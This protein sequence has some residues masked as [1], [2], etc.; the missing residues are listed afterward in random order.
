M[1]LW[2]FGRLL[3]FFSSYHVTQ[4]LVKWYL[5]IRI[6]QLQSTG[7]IKVAFIWVDGVHWRLVIPI[8]FFTVLG[9]CW[10]S[11]VDLSLCSRDI[12]SST[13]NVIW[14]F[15]EKLPS[16]WLWSSE[17]VS[18]WSA[19]KEFESSEGGPGSSLGHNLARLG[20]MSNVLF[21]P[22]YFDCPICYQSSVSDL[23]GRNYRLV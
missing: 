6:D 4:D 2:N 13:L 12:W 18:L 1:F 14:P 7:H 16:P 9:C 5:S 22:E 15:S 10:A 3:W 23:I 11:T 8:Y 19:H 21:Y 20:M 17:A